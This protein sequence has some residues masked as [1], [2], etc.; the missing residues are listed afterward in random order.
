MVGATVLVGVGAA[1]LD[2]LT[3]TERVPVPEAESL[4]LPLTLTDD[5][6]ETD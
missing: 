6:P 5:V 3:V 1:E 4:L 2:R